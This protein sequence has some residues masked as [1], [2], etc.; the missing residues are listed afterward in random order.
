[1]ARVLVIR[2]GAIGD[3]ILTLP[4]LE[5]TLLDDPLAEIEILGYPRIAE[6][7]VGRRLAVAARRVDG[8]EWA[9]LFARDGTLGDAERD[10]LAGFDSVFCVWPDED[11]TLRES[12]CR[13]GVRKVVYV[14]PMPPENGTVHAVEYMARQCCEAGLEIR[15]REP[16]LYPS[17]RDRWWV[18]RYMRV[19]GAGHRALLGLHPGSGSAKKN[20]PAPRYAEIAR[21]WMRERDGHVLVVAGP[22][23]DAPVTE[24]AAELD[25]ES[26]F[27]MRNEPLPR[28]AA[29]L[30]RCEAFV[31]NDS[32]ITHMAAAVRTPTVAIFG[33]TDP[34]VWRP[35]APQVRIVRIMQPELDIAAIPVKTVIK[36]IEEL[37]RV[38]NR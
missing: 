35:L 15:H 28:V 24:L 36:Q 8:V 9:P 1:M 2:G 31:G 25:Q 5:A 17:V 23:D 12:L 7:A 22:A 34:R 14:N 37:L 6:L 32:G 20:W 16:H 3:F 13:A 29:A 19:S 21:N 26:T 11:G 38:N 10:A 33:P 30:E 27:I 18:E 4:I